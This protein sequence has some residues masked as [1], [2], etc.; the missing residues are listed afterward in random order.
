M[1]KKY[2]ERFIFKQKCDLSNFVLQTFFSKFYSIDKDLYP[3]EQEHVNDLTSV[4]LVT[5][6]LV[7][8]FRLL[9]FP[10]GFI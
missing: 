3:T 1:W 5:Y 4:L 2:S 6:K 8:K 10:L 7:K 9:V